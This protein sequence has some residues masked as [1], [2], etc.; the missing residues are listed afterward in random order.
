LLP[1]TTQKKPDFSE[2][3]EDDLL[4]NQKKVPHKKS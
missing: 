4:E 1:Q 3:E 2:E